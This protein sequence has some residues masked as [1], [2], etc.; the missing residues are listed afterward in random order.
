MKLKVK[1]LKHE[2]TKLQDKFGKF[3][4]QKKVYG[5]K[6]GNLN[7]VNFGGGK[8]FVSKSVERALEAKKRKSI[9]KQIQGIK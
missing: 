5:V 7:Q 6:S 2:N 4:P 9:S 8:N 1:H 3:S